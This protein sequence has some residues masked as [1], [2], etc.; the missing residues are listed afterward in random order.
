MPLGEVNF[1]VVHIVFDDGTGEASSPMME[2]AM[3]ARRLRAAERLKWLPAFSVLHQA[4]DLTA[5]SLSLYQAI[6][7][8]NYTADLDASRAT[9]DG[10]AKAVR[11]ELQNLALVIHEWAVHAP[12]PARLE[13]NLCLED[14]ESKRQLRVSTKL[15]F[16]GRAVRFS[17]IR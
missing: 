17:S 5:E 4:S 9:R 6:V 14:A 12:S 8:A 2:M 16:G 3:R 15:S 10:A 11:T 13:Q 7:Q 1:E